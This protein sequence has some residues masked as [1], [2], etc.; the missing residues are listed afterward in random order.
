MRPPQTRI[1]A[2]GILSLACEGGSDFG[3]AP[4]VFGATAEKALDKGSRIL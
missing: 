4:A 3:G 1:T 2:R